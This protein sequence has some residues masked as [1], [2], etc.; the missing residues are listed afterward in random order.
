MNT[1]YKIINKIERLIGL[2]IKTSILLTC[3]LIIAI[4]CRTIYATDFGYRKVTEQQYV[5]WRKSTQLFIYR[6]TMQCA[7]MHNAILM[8]NDIEAHNYRSANNRVLDMQCSL[9]DSSRP[10]SIVKTYAHGRIALVIVDASEKTYDYGSIQHPYKK[11]KIKTTYALS[12][13]YVF[14]YDIHNVKELKNK[15]IK[16]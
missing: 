7:N 10:V 1:Y 2:L 8:F 9:S 12:N 3:V 14:T 6:N 13:Q 4:F 15:F 16:N 11:A 5:K